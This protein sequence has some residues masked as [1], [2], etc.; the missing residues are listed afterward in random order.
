MAMNLNHLRNLVAI[1]VITGVSALV[2]L[3]QFHR[4]QA[5]PILT[6]VQQLPSDVEQVVKDYA[7]Q[8]TNKEMRVTLSGRQVVHRGGKVLGLRSNVYKSYYFEGLRGSIHTTTGNLYF[9]ASDAVWDPL[10]GAPMTLN[11]NVTIAINGE[12]IHQVTSA[13]IFLKQRVV[14]ISA[15]S[16]NRYHF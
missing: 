9:S 13:R 14:E 15:D 12:Q 4:N 7:Y 8:E 11:N 16:R 1:A 10:S 6:D 2:L 5:S 3:T